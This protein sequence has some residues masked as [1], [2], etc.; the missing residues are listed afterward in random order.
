M[1]IFEAIK[2]PVEPC[3]IESIVVFSIQYWEMND[4]LLRIN[5]IPIY[6]FGLLV[7]F[8][9]LWGSFV[10]FKKANES[11]FE[12]NV[13]LDSVVLSAFW[14]FI[15]GRLIYAVVNFGMFWNHWSRLFL[16]T[17][18][19]GLDRFGAIFGIAFGLWLC[20][21]KI[22]D[23]FLNWFD[24]VSLGISAGTAVFYAGLAIMAF[25]WQFVVFAVA[26]LLV[27][28]YFWNVEGKY[29]TFDWY[30]NNKTSARSGFIS[31]FS[32]SLWGLLFLAEN[33]LNSKLSW[34]VGLWAGLLF[35]GGLVL[36]YIRSGRTVADDINLVF[37][38]G[39]R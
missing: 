24:L 36:V 5:N 3:A 13:I 28:I 14:G 12:D 15:L 38:H 9:F 18:Y 2:A 4:A 29:R 1:G 8:S 32:I 39:K 17:N 10:Y 27:Y 19:P 30:R 21:R 31:G 11:N 22:K 16:L 23:K 20:L 26:F 7:V 37:K 34:Q 33:F 25:M 6:G 35:V